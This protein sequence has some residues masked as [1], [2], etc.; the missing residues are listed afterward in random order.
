[1]GTDT[2]TLKVDEHSP[3]QSGPF[4]KMRTFEHQVSYSLTQG[5]YFGDYMHFYIG[6]IKGDPRS[7]DKG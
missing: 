4:Q 2:S 7:L 3:I 1:M 6:G 5:G